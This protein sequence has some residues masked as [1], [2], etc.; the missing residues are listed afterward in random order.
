[1]PS[2]T[3]VQAEG[4]HPP[5]PFSPSSS[6]TLRQ[7]SGLLCSPNTFPHAP[8]HTQPP[9]LPPT[10]PTPPLSALPLFLARSYST[11]R[12]QLRCHFFQKN[13]ADHPKL[14]RGALACSH[15]PPQPTTSLI[16]AFFIIQ[17][18]FPVYSSVCPCKLRSL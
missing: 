16:V 5:T 10:V 14:R 3:S 9:A 13:A 2:V 1:M 8:P 18:E 12:F 11:F 6:L 4:A 7:T 17:S 15:D